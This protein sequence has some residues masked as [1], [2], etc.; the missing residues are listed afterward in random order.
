LGSVVNL[1]D[2]IYKNPTTWNTAQ[3]VTDPQGNVMTAGFDLPPQTPGGPPPVI[4]EGSV[5]Q[6]YVLSDNV[7]F[8]PDSNGNGLQSALATPLQTANDDPALRN[9][10]WSVNQGK[11]SSPA[12]TTPLQT[13]VAD[14]APSGTV[15][16]TVNNKTPD[17]GLNVDPSS[18]T[19]NSSLEFSIT[20]TNS[21]IRT[22]GAYVQFYDSSGVQDIPTWNSNIP[23]LPS[24]ET[25]NTKFLMPIQPETVILGISIE[26]STATLSF[27]WPT[28]SSGNMIGTS[29]RLIF[30]SLGESGYTDPFCTIGGVLTG[31]FNYGFPLMFLF[32]GISAG[33]SL[34]NI[35]TNTPAML[36]ITAVVMGL[37]VTTGDM[38]D[39]THFLTVMA[40]MIGGLLVSVVLKAIFVK[41]L[42]VMGADEVAEAIPVVGWG[43]RAAAVLGNGIQIARTTEQIRSAVATLS[44]DITP[45]V[46]I[47]V[48]FGPDPRHGD[49]G[50]KGSAVWP[51]LADTYTVTI[52]YKGGTSYTKNGTFPSVESGTWIDLDFYNMPAVG[53]FQVVVAVLSSSGWLCGSFTSGWQAAWTPGTAAPQLITVSGTITEQLAPLTADTTYSYKNRLSMIP[54]PL[55]PPTCGRIPRPRRNGPAWARAER[56]RSP[57]SPA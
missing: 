16:W 39:L 15:V 10:C 54:A 47:T 17:N 5:M 32:Q 29:A 14:T 12:A 24:L 8:G 38:G 43:M 31:I 3:N 4:K 20:V 18:I 52:Q 2:T 30:G 9:Q 42:V 7:L 21:Y 56:V 45:Y 11:P 51:A 34:S 27:T 33:G 13:S 44:V 26:E 28:D 46:P 37:I 19:F 55:R 35:L 1:T 23:N 22:L 53:T 50:H 6:H 25:N 49:P 40:S 48:K 41:L 36:A 57:R